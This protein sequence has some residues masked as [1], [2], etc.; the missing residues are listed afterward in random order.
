MKASA[1]NVLEKFDSFISQELERLEKG[2]TDGGVLDAKVKLYNAF[3]RKTSAA[4]R[5]NVAK[6]FPKIVKF[7]SDFMSTEL[8]QKTVNSVIH[9]YL[10]VPDNVFDIPQEDLDYFEWKKN[11]VAKNSLA[12]LRILLELAA[13]SCPVAIQW[14]R[15]ENEQEQRYRKRRQKQQK[16]LDTYIEEFKQNKSDVAIFRTIIKQEYL[17]RK[18]DFNEKRSLATL[19][20]WRSRMAKQGK[21]PKTN[22]NNSHK[23]FGGS[24]KI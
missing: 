14:Q 10:S 23:G 4:Q 2:L 3:Q 20:A 1:E 9:A 8:E 24:N 19:K 7:F 15:F 16:R 22:P 18:P 17:N 6:R 5:K 21:L 13:V 11:P 12:R